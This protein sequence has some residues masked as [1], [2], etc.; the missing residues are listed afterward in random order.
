M[1]ITTVLAFA[2]PSAFAQPVAA[3]STNDR[4][5]D[6]EFSQADIDHRMR[7]SRVRADR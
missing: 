4:G 3:A 2:A 7:R 5:Q 1:L 6:Q